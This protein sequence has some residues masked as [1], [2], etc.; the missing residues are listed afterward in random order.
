MKI[1]FSLLA[2]LVMGVSLL[3]G[4]QHTAAGFGED[5]QSNG[6]A[7]EKSVNKNSANKN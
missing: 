1:N 3:A 7:I 5:M 4:C 6:K 2:C